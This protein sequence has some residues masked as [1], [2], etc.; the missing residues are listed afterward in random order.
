MLE[1]RVLLSV[2]IGTPQVVNVSRMSD[3]QAEETIAVNPTNPNQIFLA[4]N[5]Q[6]MSLFGATSSDGGATWTG[7]TFATGADGLPRA[8][9]DPSAAFDSFGNLFF[10]YLGEDSNNAEVLLSTDGGQTFTHVA[11]LPGHADQPTISVGH[12]SMWVGFQQGMNSGVS[13]GALGVK[14]AGALMY[15][16]TVSGLGQ[17]GRFGSAIPLVGP[18]GQNVADIAVGPA[19]QV[20]VAY[21][22]AGTSN[23]SIFIKRD[24]NGLRQHSFGPA[25]LVG[26]TNVGDA[27]AI[28]AQPRRTIDAEIGLAYDTSGDGYA[29]RVYMVY[30]DRANANTFDTDIFLRFS[31]DDGLT[32]SA[33]ARVNDDSTSASQFFPRIAV[34]PT[35]GLVGI[36][37]Y[38]GRNDTGDPSAGGGT[39]TT[40]DNEAQ[41]YAAVGTPTATGVDFSAPNFP[42]TTA[43]SKAS[44]SPDA[45]D[46]GDY[47]GLAFYG[48]VLRPTWADNSDSTGDN[49]NGA[50]NANNAYAAAASVQDPTAPAGR[51]LLGQFGAV[52]GRLTIATP[53]GGRATLSLAGGG[54]GFAVQDGSAIDLTLRN[55]GPRSSLTVTAPAI[56]IGSVVA[57]SSIAS[58]VAPGADLTGTFVASG[59]VQRITLGSILRGIVAAVGSV[60]TFRAGNLTGA[61]VLSGVNLGSDNAIG[62]TGA[63][64]D[65]YSQGRINSFVVT[66]SVVNSLVSAGFAPADGTFDNTQGTV[67]GGTASAIRLVNVPHSTD[68]DTRFVAGAFGT[69]ILGKRIRGNIDPR[70]VVL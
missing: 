30:T 25:I 16:A 10:V 53:A 62:G 7:R 50:D 9:C 13:S 69:V 22:S 43:F 33:P 26:K 45:N 32:W 70:V 28:P 17:V 20:L 19:G 15:G 63:A 27:L 11:S 59:S 64:A 55:T 68:A 5:E 29:G 60:A 35:T 1:T 52:G 23:S 54:T 2:S 38:D 3:Q 51:T 37:W 47:T 58:F 48:G 67:V 21:Q 49:P 42:V 14:N 46:F 8:C 65:T 39:D 36:S 18:P 44:A 66:G 4:S 40:A 31:D 61:K 24:P 12:G 57:P 6:G 34:D 41:V 56:T